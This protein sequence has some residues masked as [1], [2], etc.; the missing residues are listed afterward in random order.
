MVGEEPDMTITRTHTL[1]A[2]LLA[3]LALMAA[4][5]VTRALL[6]GAERPAATGVVRG[7]TAPIPIWPPSTPKPDRDPDVR[8]DVSTES[9]IRPVKG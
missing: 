3:G 2:G 1:V 5:N 9:S 7:S 8:P 6:S 4:T